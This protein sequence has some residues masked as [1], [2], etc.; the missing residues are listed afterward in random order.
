MDRRIDMLE[1]FNQTI[2]FAKAIEEDI[3]ETGFAPTD[4][5][6][7]QVFSS[8]ML[9]KNHPQIYKVDKSLVNL[10]FNT[11]NQIFPRKP[12]YNNIFL[13][14]DFKFNELDIRGMI[15]SFLPIPED[16][17]LDEYW[18]NVEH[19][20]ESIK[21]PVGRSIMEEQLKKFYKKGLLSNELLEKDPATFARKLMI[22]GQKE[23]ISNCIDEQFNVKSLENDRFALFIFAWGFDNSDNTIF[24]S[25]KDLAPPLTYN[26]YGKQF[27]E[28]KM[29]LSKSYY[30]EFTLDMSDVDKFA[31]TLELFAC[32][33]LDFINNPEV[34]II[35]HPESAAR[36]KKRKMRG[37]NLIPEYNDIRITGELK[38]YIGKTKNKGLSQKRVFD[39]KYWVS[40]HFRR[41]WDKEKHKNMYRKHQEKQLSPKYYYDDV[42]DVLMTWIIPYVKGKGMLVS[43]PHLLM[44]P[45]GKK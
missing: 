16:K 37:K 7:L 34:K 13:N 28:E 35:N 3:S 33:F 22:L 18:Y 8:I 27:T 40:G 5:R 45:G 42:N 30:E 23:Q 15:I 17:A 39:H 25:H 32:N 21:T 24:Y 20:L 38:K 44:K 1:H 2:N 36:N 12:P 10:L 6:L 19:A 4:Y 31:G 26:T 41:F 29:Q 9:Y 11:K 43:K 14:L